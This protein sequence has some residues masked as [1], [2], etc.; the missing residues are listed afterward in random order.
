[1]ASKYKFYPET[2]IFILSEE[3]KFLKS[4]L[5]IYFSCLRGANM[6]K[7]LFG[8]SIGLLSIATVI[9]ATVVVAFWAYFLIKHQDKKYLDHD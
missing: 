8:S 2:D 6:L 9:G 1:M 4:D 7:V 5:L 3:E